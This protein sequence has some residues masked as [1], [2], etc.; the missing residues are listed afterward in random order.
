M[1]QANREDFLALLAAVEETAQEY[2]DSERISPPPAKKIDWLCRE[3]FERPESQAT[4][5]PRIQ[6]NALCREHYKELCERAWKLWQRGMTDL[7]PQELDIGAGLFALGVWCKKNLPEEKPAHAGPPRSD[8]KP[9]AQEQPGRLPPAVAAGTSTTVGPPADSEYATFWD[10]YHKMTYRGETMLLNDHQATIMK[11]LAEG[12][13]VDEHTLGAAINTYSTRYRLL[14][15]FRAHRKYH[16]AW[17][18]IKKA[19]KGVYRL[20]VPVKV[21]T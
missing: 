3:R 4:L 5:N 21:S 8:Q 9:D 16:P 2:R 18:L 15:S 13:P 6:L 17:R 19:S 14:D 1:S 20:N 11:I 7:P 10:E 12:K